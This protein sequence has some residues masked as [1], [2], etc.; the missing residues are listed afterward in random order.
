MIAEAA[1]RMSEES[2]KKLLGVDRW[3]RDV[4]WEEALEI[5]NSFEMEAPKVADIGTGC[6]NIAVSLA[7]EVAGVRITATDV[8]REVL[9][10]YGNMSSPTALFILERMRRERRTLPCVALGFGPGLAAEAALFGPASH[11]GNGKGH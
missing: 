6:G 10:E 1:R 11:E 4:G 5:L 7:H 2:T 3:I 9:S 8:S